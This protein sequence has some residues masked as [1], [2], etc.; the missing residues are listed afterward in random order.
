MIA[1]LTPGPDFKQFLQ[2]V[3]A[4]RQSNKTVCQRRHARLTGVHVRNHFQFSQATMCGFCF[5]Q[6]LRN[7]AHRLTSGGKYGIRHNAHQP[8]FAAAID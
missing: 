7:N 2:G 8:F 3:Y 5:Y 6:P 4:A 1:D